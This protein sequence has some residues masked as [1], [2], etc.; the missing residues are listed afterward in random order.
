MTRHLKLL[1]AC[2]TEDFRKLFPKGAPLTKTS[3]KKARKVGLELGWFRVATRE[4]ISDHS[5]NLCPKGTCG[6]CDGIRKDSK[7]KSI[8]S[9]LKLCKKVVKL[10]A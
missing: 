2:D 7:K 1:G 3:V 9:L 5:R 4:F 8:Q 6:Y 10:I